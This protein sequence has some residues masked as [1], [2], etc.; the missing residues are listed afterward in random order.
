[1]NLENLN[2]DQ[3]EAV[4]SA[5]GACI[6]LAGPGTGKTTTLAHR[7]AYLLERK[8]VPGRQV[9]AVTFTRAAAREMR[10][11]VR[12]L[13][14]GS[15]L[16]QQADEA[17]I[18]T[19]HAAAR[20]ILRDENYPFGPGVE[21]KIASDEEKKAAAE[22]AAPGREAASFLE[23]VRRAKQNLTGPEV[24]AF[25]DY[26]SRLFNAR[27]LDF[28]DL[29][30]YVCRLFE[31]RPEVLSRYRARFRYVLVDEFQDTSLAQYR[32]LSQ[33]FPKNLCALGDP[34]QAIYGF[35]GGAFEPFEAFRRDRPAA[36]VLP[37]AQNYR[38]QLTILEAA[39]QVIGR[40]PERLPRSLEARLEQ[41]LPVE[42]SACRTDL[43]EAEM[44]ARRIEDLIGGSSHFAVDSRWARK[45]GESGTYGLQDIAV[46]YRFHAQA[47]LLRKALERSGLPF[48]VFAKK[49]PSEA[50]LPFG[51]DLEDFRN[52]DAGLEGEG[53]TLM[54][55]HR[56]KGLEFPVVFILGC[57]DGILPYGRS[58][59]PEL[60]AKEIEEERRLFYVGMTRAKSRVFLS[61][62]AQR[63]L[64][65]RTLEAPPS[66]FLRE[67]EERLRLLRQD[68]PPKKK[69]PKPDQ[70]QLF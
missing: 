59:E 27:R 64:F 56:S 65:G 20:R 58:A 2:P 68:A 13:L 47:R 60:R 67:M 3:R 23:E 40:N 33:L 37:L 48:R 15:A 7:V 14:S 25:G 32:I 26:Q 44:T 63:F 10:E 49:K 69:P 38:S 5:E 39:K 12:A 18:E 54:S 4:L 8:R 53:V 43:Q 17:W 50:E 31:E 52:D 42:I 55:L 35:Q 66:P 34:D 28:D 9:L 41:G 70:L 62:A 45:D 30:S 61:H 21:W 22:A 29:L 51:E 6:V 36:R 24:P 16:E 11:R 19:F 1:M 57:E 46:L